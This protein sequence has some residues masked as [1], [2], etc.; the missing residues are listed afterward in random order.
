MVLKFRTTLNL[1]ILLKGSKTKK[2][3]KGSKNSRGVTQVK[4]IFLHI[5]K[6]EILIYYDNKEIH[7]KKI[8]FLA[9]LYI[10]SIVFTY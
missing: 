4:A 10:L 6:Q 8:W 3:M 1:E 7:A 9:V 5:K 2:I